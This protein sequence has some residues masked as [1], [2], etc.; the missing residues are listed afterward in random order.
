MNTSKHVKDVVKCKFCDSMDVV[1]NGVRAGTQ[2]WLC[3][4]CGHGFVDN[5]ALPRDRY[6]LSV[7]ANAVMD[8]YTGKSLTGIRLGIK[9]HTGLEPSDSSIYGWFKEFTNIAL[10]E[11]KLHNPIVSDK[12]IIDETVVAL[13]DNKKYWLIN[14]IDSESRFLLASKM[15]TNRSTKDIISTIKLA[16]DKV[17]KNP[18]TIVT[19]GWRGYPESVET[20]FG[21]DCKHIIGSPFERDEDKNTNLIERYNG[22]L[23]DRLKTMRGMDKS[24]NIQLILEGFIVYYNYLR[25]HESLN[26]KTPAEVAKVK[27]PFKDWLDVAKTKIPNAVEVLDDIKDEDLPQ[28]HNVKKT[29]KKLYRKRVVIK[30]SNALSGVKIN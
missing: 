16:C 15:S 3:T 21:A 19:D 13:K 8:Y 24:D 23:K 30:G 25:P 5:G 26:G 2:Y 14:V 10:R 7:K 29:R 22:T 12:W 20:L 1:K 11:A 4:N 27:F 18:T 6:Q 28:K 17:G 9:Q